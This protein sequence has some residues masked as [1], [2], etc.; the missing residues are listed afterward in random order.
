MLNIIQ[1]KLSIKQLKENLSTVL[2]SN[3]VYHGSPNQHDFDSRGDIYNGTFFSTN[4][5]EAKAYGEF[6]YEVKLNPNIKIFDTNNLAD[7]RIL[8]NNFGELYDDYYDENEEAH[9]IRTPE[10]LYHHS[11]S[12]N[13]IENTN[14]VLEWLDGIYDGVKIFEGGVANI[15]IFNPIKEKIQSLKLINKIMNKNMNISEDS[16]IIIKRLLREELEENKL[17]RGLTTVGM[18]LSTM[19]GN[20]ATPNNAKTDSIETTSEFELGVKRNT[21]GTFTSTAKT[22]G[23]TKEF[24]KD[25]AINKAKKQLLMKLDKNEAAI[26]NLE[27]V[28]IFFK[29]YKGLVVCTVKLKITI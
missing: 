14:G 13:A 15:L 17:T 20:G 23:P 6:V 21:D 22:D 16:K 28:N 2:K 29:N 12:W 7:I 10:E 25:L 1:N 9:Y 3:I 8:M 18:A 27:I 5:N 24:A 4:E 11:D 26:I 19:V